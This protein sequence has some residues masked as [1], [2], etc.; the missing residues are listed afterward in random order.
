[1][2]M[3]SIQRNQHNNYYA[4]FRTYSPKYGPVYGEIEQQTNGRLYVNWPGYSEFA[5]TGSIW[6]S[7]ERRRALFIRCVLNILDP[8]RSTNVSNAL[9]WYRR[10]N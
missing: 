7:A 1:M 9:A 10:Q 5:G 3:S 8:R 6:L 4:L 2:F